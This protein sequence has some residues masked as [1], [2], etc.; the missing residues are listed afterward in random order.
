[1]VF[2]GFSEVQSKEMCVRM[3]GGGGGGRRYIK[4]PYWKGLYMYTL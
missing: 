2:K 3:G 1:M 4:V